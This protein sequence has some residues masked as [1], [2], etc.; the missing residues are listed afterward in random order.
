MAF[1]AEVTDAELDAWG[2]AWADFLAGQNWGDIVDLGDGND[3]I[4]AGDD[5]DLI[6]GGASSVSFVFVGE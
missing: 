1:G 3:K 2:A 4:D 5:D 6:E